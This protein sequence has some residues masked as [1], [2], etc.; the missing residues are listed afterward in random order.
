[1]G[2]FIIH[3]VQ[4][5]R[6]IFCDPQQ[7]ATKVLLFCLLAVQFIVCETSFY[8]AAVVEHAPISVPGQVSREEAISVMNQ[9]LDEY[10]AHI[11][12]AKE[13]GSEI[14][15]FPEDGLYGDDKCTRTE[16]LPY[17]EYIPDPTSSSSFIP[18]NDEPYIFPHE[19]ATSYNASMFSKQPILT[20]ISCLAQQ[21]Q[22]VIVL[23]MGDIQPC[24]PSTDSSCPSDGRYQYNTQ[25]AFDEQ[26]ALLAKYHKTHLFYEPQFNPAVPSDPTTFTTSFGVK[27]AMMICFDMMFATPSEYYVQMNDVF[28]VVYSTWWINTPPDFSATQI[29]QAWSRTMNL[30]LLA[31]GNGLNWLYSGSGIFS[32]GQVLQQ[33]YNPTY[34]PKD[35]LLVSKVPKFQSK[36]EQ[37]PHQFRE[38]LNLLPKLNYEKLNEKKAM[39]NV[40]HDILPTLEEYSIHCPVNSSSYDDEIM[41]GKPNF[42]HLFPW[43]NPSLLNAQQ[44]NNYWEYSYGTLAYAG[45]FNA[46]WGGKNISH[47][48]V[49]NNLTCTINFDVAANQPFLREYGEEYYTVM[50]YTGL[51]DGTVDY[52]AENFCAFYRCRTADVTSCFESLIFAGTIFEKFRLEGNYPQG[53]TLYGL[54]ATDELRL[55][56]ETEKIE[57]GLEAS[58]ELPEL[59]GYLQAVHEFDTIL[60]NASLLGR[61]L[62]EDDE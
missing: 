62:S 3:F 14:I 17:L 54:A 59:T 12:A 38:N 30:N 37:S 23:D 39:R 15:V 11:Q 56:E 5:I 18:C 51:Y 49:A 53:T 36:K 1:M 57:V 9:N 40:V 20:R 35:A 2:V 47:T 8:T 6:I 55:I 4:A 31:S 25:V 48:A 10:V 34:Q 32:R 52:Y 13:L 60:L 22:I 46:T 26:G 61:I 21:Y 41:K 19:S 29:Q 27:F 50:A 16:I 45:P 7:M 33:H 58:P 42:F 24:D 43:K 28:D 44:E